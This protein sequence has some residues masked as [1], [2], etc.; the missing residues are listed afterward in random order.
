MSTTRVV[1][2]CKFGKNCPQVGFIPDNDVVQAFAPY[3]SDDAFCISL[4]TGAARRN[5]SVTNATSFNAPFEY[6]AVFCVVATDQE[7]GCR[8][9]REGFV[10]LLRQPQCRWVSSC[11]EQRNMPAVG[12]DN[13]QRIKLSLIDGR[14]S[15]KID[16]G[17]AVHLD[18]EERAPG[19]TAA[20]RVDARH[21]LRD[22]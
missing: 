11:C 1:V 7:P 15:E 13:D 6:M 8:V 21:I 5:R 10:D 17:D 9:P 4:L 18:R 16:G 2:V 12:A 20:P 19:R 22:R 3:R 14:N